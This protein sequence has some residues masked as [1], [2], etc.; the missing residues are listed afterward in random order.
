MNDNALR[1]VEKACTDLLD[2]G[3]TV[4]FTAVAARSGLARTT[5]YRNQRLRAVI[6]EHRTRQAEARTL[7]SLTSEI[8]HLRT[9]L[10][11]VAATVRRHEEQLRKLEGCRTAD[12]A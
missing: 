5:L 4:T 10:Q 11:A 3:E 8:A 12:S 2:T 6:D 1:R 7:S 9:A